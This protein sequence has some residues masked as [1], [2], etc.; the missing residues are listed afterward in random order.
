MYYLYDALVAGG[1]VVTSGG[2]LPELLDVQLDQAHEEREYLRH[3]AGQRLV[4]VF[5]A[6]VLLQ[7]LLGITLFFLLS[8]SINVSL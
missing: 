2:L 1:R 7:S 8:T 4:D 6:L 3:V 5:A